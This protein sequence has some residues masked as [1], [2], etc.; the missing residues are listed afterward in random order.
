MQQGSAVEKRRV[1][2]GRVVGVGVPGTVVVIQ[3][4]TGYYKKHLFVATNRTSGYH[5][6][7]Q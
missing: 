6:K 2:E 3:E 1:K 5:I 7:D 4:G